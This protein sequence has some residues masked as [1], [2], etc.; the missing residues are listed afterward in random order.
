MKKLNSHSFCSSLILFYCQ[1]CFS[2]FSS[3]FPN[4]FFFLSEF[5]DSEK[6]V[7]GFLLLY[8]SQIYIVVPKHILLTVKESFKK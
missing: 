3:F 7:A 5:G 4:T 2:F 6:R 8:F 1:S